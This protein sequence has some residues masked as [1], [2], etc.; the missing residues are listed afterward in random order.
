M[1]SKSDDK[2]SGSAEQA[3]S[4]RVR[5]PGFLLEEE[6]GLGDVVGKVTYAMGIKAC[7]GCERR[8]EMLNHWMRF[9]R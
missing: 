2:K 1:T 6:L 7:S 4:H 8:A 5:M 3:P 9:S